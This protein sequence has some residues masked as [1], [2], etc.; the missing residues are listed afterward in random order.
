MDLRLIATLSAIG[1]TLL[2]FLA[3]RFATRSARQPI[4]IERR[5]II[6]RRSQSNKF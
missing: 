1:L 5:R 2:L 6:Y 4:L 3:N